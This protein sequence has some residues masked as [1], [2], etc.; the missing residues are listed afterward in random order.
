MR[1]ATEACG[2]PAFEQLSPLKVT[3]LLCRARLLQH[4]AQ[5][6]TP[7]LLLLRGKK[8]GVLRET[9]DD[10]ALALFRRAAEELG[11]HVATMRSGLSAS[12][13]PQDVQH[14]ARMLGRLYDAVECQGMAPALV[15]QI[16]RHAG[17]PVC[18]GAAMESHATARLAGLLGDTSAL[19]DNRR[20]VLQ[21]LLLESMA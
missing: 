20:F 6:G 1:L 18:E 10:A 16:A 17:I 4:A 5:A 8:L 14:T 3:S 11:A 15:Q 13:A 2:P 12:S 9:Q 7:P 19:A 21:A